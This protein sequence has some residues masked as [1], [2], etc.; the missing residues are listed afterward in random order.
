[1][2]YLRSA[3]V[4][5][6]VVPGITSAVAALAYAGVPVTQ[7]GVAANF[8]VITGHRAGDTSAAGR[9]YWQSLA[10]LDTLIILMGMKNLSHI[11]EQLLQAGKSPTTPALVVQWGTLP[12]QQMVS[13]PLHALPQRVTETGVR[14]PAVIVIGA[15]AE[16]ANLLL[17]AEQFAIT[18]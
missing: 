17:P 6:E 10:Q 16:L 11:T 12:H 5:V 7:R 14:A 9:S 18:L 13:A 4:P 1:M 15:V 2:A 3:G 8:G